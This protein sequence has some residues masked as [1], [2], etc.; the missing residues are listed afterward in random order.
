MKEGRTDYKRR[1]KKNRRDA[2]EQR[3][4][5]TSEKNGTRKRRSGNNRKQ[6]PKAREADPSRKTGKKPGSRNEATKSEDTVTAKRRRG[7]RSNETTD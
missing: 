1:Q 6:A 3:N 2:A 7:G 4:R 5:G